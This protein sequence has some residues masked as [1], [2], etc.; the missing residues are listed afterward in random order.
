MTRTDI[1]DYLGLTPET[2]SRSLSM[3]K[4]LKAVQTVGADAVRLLKRDMVED[5]AEAV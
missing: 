4:R 2:V 5:L 1:A 3:L